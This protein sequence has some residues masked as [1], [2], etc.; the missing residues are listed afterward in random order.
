ME[1]KISYPYIFG[2][3]IIILRVDDG[4]CAPATYVIGIGKMRP[5]RSG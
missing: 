1:R 4:V 2:Q 3:R 5:E